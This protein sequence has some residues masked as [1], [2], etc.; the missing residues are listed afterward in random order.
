MQPDRPPILVEHARVHGKEQ[1][2]RALAELRFQRI[3]GPE[4]P[5]VAFAD[6]FDPV[7]A[8]VVAADGEVGPFEDLYAAM[9]G[10]GLRRRSAALLPLRCVAAGEG[11]G[12][13]A[14]EE[15]S[16]ANSRRRRPGR[17]RS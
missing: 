13:G 4:R 2:A 9:A 8:P 5:A 3:E 6:E 1:P 12:E 7:R 15:E 16:R 14:G 11:E 10:F 17:P